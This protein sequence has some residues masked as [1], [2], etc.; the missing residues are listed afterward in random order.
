[1]C[2]ERLRLLD[3]YDDA[4]ERLASITSDLKDA[5]ACSVEE[6]RAIR[7][8]ADSELERVLEA[9]LALH[10]HREEHGC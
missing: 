3:A 4:V 8:K 1:M 6:F 5:T 10:R 2:E 7:H 9:K